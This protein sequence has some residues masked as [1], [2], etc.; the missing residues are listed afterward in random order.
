M[1]ANDNSKPNPE[2][3]AGALETEGHEGVTAFGEAPDVRATGGSAD[4]SGET[5]AADADRARLEAEKADLTER[6]DIETIARKSTLA[7]GPESQPCRPSI[8]VMSWA[9]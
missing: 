5:A 2:Q 7:A 9:V 3:T 6:L 8:W 4:T 1:N